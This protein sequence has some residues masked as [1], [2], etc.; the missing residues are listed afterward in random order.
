MIMCGARLHR[1][2][3]RGAWGGFQDALVLA[4][5]GLRPGSSRGVPGPGA[6]HRRTTR[7]ITTSSLRVFESGEAEYNAELCA[8]PRRTPRTRPIPERRP[9][10]RSRPT[11]APHLSPA[12]TR[13]SPTASTHLDHKDLTCEN[14]ADLDYLDGTRRPS[15][16]LCQVVPT[17]DGDVAPRHPLETV[18]AHPLACQNL[19][20]CVRV[21]GMSRA[22]VAVA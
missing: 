17:I 5:D 10:R 15:D 14:A 2:T 12:I 22:Q 21:L 6:T 16:N 3:A 1:R 13:V 20:A 4:G 19:T 11:G 9:P 18:P 8:P 7:V